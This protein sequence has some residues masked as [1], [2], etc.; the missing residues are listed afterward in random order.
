MY[1][2]LESILY[3]FIFLIE[4]Y[5]FFVNSFTVNPLASIVVTSLSISIIFFPILRIAKKFEDKKSIKAFAVEEKVKSLPN[6]LKGEVRFREIEKIYLENN[7]HPIQNVYKGTS[8]YLILP[9]FISAYLFFLNNINFFDIDMFG[10]LNLS[11]PDKILFGFNLL[12]LL[13]FVI[14]FLDSNYRNSG[15]LS[16]QKTYLVISFII[17]LLIYN[18]PSSMTLYWLTNSIFSLLIS[19]RILKN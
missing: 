9:I 19:I 13:I 2:F 3:P 12:P 11:K 7:F 16:G 18:M 1:D 14:N 10:I 5:F 6:T 15:K 17:C 8:F 4:K